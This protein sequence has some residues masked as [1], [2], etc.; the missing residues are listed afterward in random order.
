MRIILEYQDMHFNFIS[1]QSDLQYFTF[2]DIIPFFSFYCF[3][4]ILKQ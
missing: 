4:F 2:D 1:V 3:N